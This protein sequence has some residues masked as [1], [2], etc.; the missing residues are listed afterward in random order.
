[1]IAPNVMPDPTDWNLR[2]PKAGEAPN[3]ARRQCGE[4]KRAEARAGD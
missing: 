3:G 1:M 4:A 2:P